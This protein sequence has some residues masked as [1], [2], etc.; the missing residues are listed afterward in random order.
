[1][2]GFFTRWAEM[3]R[4]MVGQPH[5]ESYV[6]HMARHHPDRTPMNRT[7]FFRNREQARYGGKGSGR[8]C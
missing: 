3:M 2:K 8:C 1:M 4:L 5:Y 7:E 6:Q